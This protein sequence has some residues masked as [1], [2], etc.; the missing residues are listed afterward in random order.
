MVESR[1]F[2]LDR[3]FGGFVI[4]F[5]RDVDPPVAELGLLSATFG[6]FFEVVSF[7]IAER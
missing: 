1:A 6:S 3:E 4:K 2:I 5:C 7:L